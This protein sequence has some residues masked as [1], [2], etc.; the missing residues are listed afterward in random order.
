MKKLL[1]NGVLAVV[2][3]MATAGAN[4]FSVLGMCQ[5]KRP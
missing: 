2:M 1:M 5:P 4:N 3:F